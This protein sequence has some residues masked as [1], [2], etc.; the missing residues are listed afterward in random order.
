MVHLYLISLISKDM[1]LT[2]VSNCINF[3]CKDLFLATVMQKG[4][5]AET[6]EVIQ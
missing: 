4:K 2:I 5:I 3:E 6:D 1:F